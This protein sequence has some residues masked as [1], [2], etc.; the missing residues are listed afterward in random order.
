VVAYLR[1][2]PADVTSQ[3]QITRLPFVFNPLTK[4]SFGLMGVTNRGPAPIQGPVHLVFDDLG[5]GLTLLDADGAIE[6]D[7]FLT[8]NRKLRVGETWVVLV[9]FRNLGRQP[10]TFTPRVL[11]GAF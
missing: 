3:V 5:S 8:L 6:G 10:V 9:R 11:S 7:P 4:V 2:A 1:A